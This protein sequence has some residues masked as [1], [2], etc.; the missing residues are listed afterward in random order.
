MMRIRLPN[1]WAPREYQIPAW[2]Y[3][4]SGGKHAELVWHRRSG[5]DELA[6]HWA[7]YAAMQRP[8]TYWHMLPEATQARK[9]IWDAVNP[10]SGIRRIDE[11]F[12]FALRETTREHEML[13]KF[14][15]GSTWQVIG[16]DNYNS[17]VGSPPA[18][19]V[20]SE[21]PLAKPEAKAFL[22]PI[23][24][25]NNGWQLYVGTPRGPNHAKK[26]FEDAEKDPTAFAQKLTA[27]QT[28][29]FS[30]Q[31]LESER[32]A[33]INDHGV[34]IGTALFEQEYMCSFDVVLTGRM[35]F[36]RDNLAKAQ[37]ETFKHKHRTEIS[38]AGSWNKTDSGSLR[39]WDDPVPGKRYVIG[40]DVAEGLAHGD[41]SCA[42]VLDAVTGYQV[43]QWHGHIAPD[44]FGDILFHI[45]RR[46]NNALLGV[47]RNNHG[48]TTI[49]RIK[50]REY[51]NLYAQEDIER[52]FDGHQTSKAGW[53][54]TQ[55]SK[56]KII[57]QLAGELRDGDHGI[58]CE[59]TVKEMLTY[60]I[61]D[62]GSY[63]AAQGLYDDR[64]M[65]RAIA[66]EMLR[67]AY[68]DQSKAS[69]RPEYKPA[70]AVG[71]Y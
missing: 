34:D 53:L 30:P 2:Q 39:V 1:N 35:V 57:D 45:G 9:A 16:S 49:T 3:L 51:V 28:G 60:I 7:A 46:Y 20:F 41:Y 70:D 27:L 12:P 47:E 52:T 50:D 25:E 33:Y 31:M 23:F 71:G 56:F 14:V 21:W 40:A 18:G 65:S 6:L 59:E 43:A 48:L 5:K 63:G 11:A 69:P 8:A 13:I 24:A 44:L 66:G 55:K 67:V 54:T 15:N 68:I 58:A 10:H 36:D 26:S 32:K 62:N 37:K 42:D 61:N 22:R 17:L 29:V 38:P 19:V 4:A 64:V